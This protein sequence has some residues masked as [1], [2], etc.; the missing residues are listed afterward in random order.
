M[1]HQVSSVAAA[2]DYHGTFDETMFDVGQG[3]P[4]PYHRT[5]FESERIVR[6]ECP[7]PWRVYRPAVVVGHSETGEMD[8]VDGPYYAFTLIKRLRDHLPAWMPLAG[9][10][11]GDTN[12]VPVD[13]VAKALDHIAHEPGLD[14]QAFHQ[15]YELEPGTRR[16]CVVVG[17]LRA[18]DVR[19]R[20]RS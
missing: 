18:E 3:L 15:Q 14:G 7:V 17:D 2:G 19:P 11:L 16:G 20:G 9:V 8:K 12:L 4:S 6:E 1:F 13:Y 5:K 10:D